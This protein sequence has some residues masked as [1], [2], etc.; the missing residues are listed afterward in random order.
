MYL[1]NQY[2][3]FWGIQAKVA[4]KAVRISQTNMDFPA[5]FARE[6]KFVFN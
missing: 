3:S 6:M 1:K 2:S 5:C 4:T